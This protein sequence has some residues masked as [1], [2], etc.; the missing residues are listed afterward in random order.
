[1]SDSRVPDVV[2]GTQNVTV[3]KRDKTL[4]P[5]RAYIVLRSDRQSARV[6]SKIYTVLNGVKYKE[7]NKVGNGNKKCQG[8]ILLAKVT[9]ECLTV[10]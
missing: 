4:S 6:I 3:K 7:K 5:C 8:S 2:L 1:M 10:K 9:K